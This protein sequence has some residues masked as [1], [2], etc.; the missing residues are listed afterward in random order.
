MQSSSFEAQENKN[1]DRKDGR[2]TELTEKYA[3]TAD[4]LRSFSGGP[5]VA[6]DAEKRRRGITGAKLCGRSKLRITCFIDHR[7]EHKQSWYPERFLDHGQ[8]ERF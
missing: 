8:R 2:W 4:S 5:E 7:E 1:A 6:V 3:N